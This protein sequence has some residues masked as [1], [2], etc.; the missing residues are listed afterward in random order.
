MLYAQFVSLQEALGL[1][2]LKA[3]FALMPIFDCCVSWLWSEE[4]CVLTD[5]YATLA[6]VGQNWLDV[7]QH[8]PWSSHWISHSLIVSVTLYFLDKLR[9]L[10]LLCSV[11]HC[12]WSL[13]D[14]PTNVV[15]SSVGFRTNWWRPRSS[16]LLREALIVCP[17]ILGLWSDHLWVRSK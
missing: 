1:T 14:E 5:F 16:E 9:R 3:A 8:W 12:S 2:L 6:W 4:S 13:H 17:C 15:R 11:F 7:R 10:R